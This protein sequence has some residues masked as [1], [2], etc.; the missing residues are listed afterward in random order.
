MKQT[1]NQLFKG[2]IVCLYFSVCIGSA[3]AQNPFKDPPREFSVLPFWFWNDT[4]K[5]EELVRQIA[6]FEAHGVYGFVMHPRMG[7]P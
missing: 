6:D 3:A 1:L 5:D 7:L 2:V 4:L